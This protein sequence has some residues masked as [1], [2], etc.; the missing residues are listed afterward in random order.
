MKY[1]I[2]FTGSQLMA[3][4]TILATHQLCPERAESYLDISVDP[5]METKP[6]DLLLLIMTAE[7]VR[8]A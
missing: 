7:L 1:R 6:E 3:L 4:R 8:D 2:D 5:A